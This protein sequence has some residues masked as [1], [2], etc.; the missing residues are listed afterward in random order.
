MNHR[1]QISLAGCGILRV[2]ND[3][4]LRERP[5]AERVFGKAMTSGSS[6]TGELFLTIRDDLIDRSSV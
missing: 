3:S 2:C 6:G 5:H 1:Q 4:R